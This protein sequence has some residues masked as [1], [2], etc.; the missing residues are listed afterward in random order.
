[1]KPDIVFFGD[2]V[3][4]RVVQKVRE[5]VESADALLILGTSLTTYSA[6]R[7]ILQAVEAKKQIFMI[8]IGPTRADELATLKLQARCGDVLP[9]IYGFQNTS[10]QAS[11]E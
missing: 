2:N 1:M 7:I 11:I 6:Y 9:K 10:C 8:N 4:R 3:D 5:E